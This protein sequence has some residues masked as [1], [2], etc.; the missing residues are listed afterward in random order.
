MEKEGDDERDPGTG[1]KSEGERAMMT[2]LW[3]E[4]DGRVQSDMQQAHTHTHS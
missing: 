2:D 4:T 1:R 3:S